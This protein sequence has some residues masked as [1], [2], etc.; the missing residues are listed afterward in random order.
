[1]D[2]HSWPFAEAQTMWREHLDATVAEILEHQNGNFQA[3][4]EVHDLVHD[5]ALEMADFFSNGVMR[6]FPR[7]SRDISDKQGETFADSNALVFPARN[8]CCL[9]RDFQ[10]FRDIKN[11]S[12]ARSA[13]RRRLLPDFFM[14]SVIPGTPV[15][16]RY[17]SS[18]AGCT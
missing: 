5:L 15:F 9:C 14:T 10:S 3:E 2:P 13:D 18:T 6:Q 17:A 16:E 8:T 7:I 1:M 4:V 11:L 12:T